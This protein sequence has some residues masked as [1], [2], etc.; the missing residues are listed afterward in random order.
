MTRERE[1]YKVT[2]VGSIGNMLLLT[3]K[4][5]AGIVG[6]SSAMIA[7]AVHSLSDFLTD[8]IVIIFVRISAKPQ[9][10]SHDYG[11]GK[12]E[13]IA[14]FIIALALM[15]AATGIIIAGGSKLVAW[16]GGEQL[17]APGLLA[18]WAAL[19]SIAVKEVLYQYTAHRG[20][21]LDSQ[22]MVAN[23]WH[24]RSDALSSVG[25]AIGI[26]GAIFLGNRWT[27]LDP[28]ASIVVGLML[29]KVAFNLLKTSVG[30]LTEGSLP[31]ETE[32]EILG[33]ILSFPDVEQPHNLRT[34]RIG[35]RIAIEAHVRMDGN[36]PLSTVHD[37]ASAI[38]RR[39]KERFGSKTHVTLH[40][41]P[42]KSTK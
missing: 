6:H 35:N 19:L 13:T 10:D 18:L 40:M 11:H 30:E 8:I 20:K 12:F 14:S 1:I 27:V 17:A 34:R 24:H 16:S 37:R 41:E 38:E 29:V 26:G 21:R 23:A 31:A 9:D 36:L 28:V 42:L 15:A 39:L 4:F 22:V 7:D 3:F 25:T 2:L 5:I 33:I 32:D